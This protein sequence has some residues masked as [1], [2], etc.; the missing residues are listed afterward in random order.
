MKLMMRI[1][2]K[3]MM[4]FIM[5]FMMRFIM[6]FMIGV[7]HEVYDKLHDELYF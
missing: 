2:M 5:K 4:R 1:I 7:R 3:L 6:K